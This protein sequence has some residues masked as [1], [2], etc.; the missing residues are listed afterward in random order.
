MPMMDGIFTITMSHDGVRCEHL[1]PDAGGVL[2]I[3]EDLVH[4]RVLRLKTSHQALQHV[5]KKFLFFDRNMIT[6]KVL[7]RT[8]NLPPQ[9]LE[10]R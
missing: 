4:R 6:I 5:L 8:E 9:Y 3:V 10:R 2:V 1:Q 7:V